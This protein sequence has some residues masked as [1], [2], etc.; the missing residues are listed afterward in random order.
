ML[1]FRRFRSKSVGEVACAQVSSRFFSGQ[2]LIPELKLLKC[3]VCADS[4]QFWRCCFRETSAIQELER[5]KADQE[6]FKD[7][8]EKSSCY[9]YWGTL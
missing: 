3:E 6:F 2:L 7:R 4:K 1:G 8:S 5:L 9:C